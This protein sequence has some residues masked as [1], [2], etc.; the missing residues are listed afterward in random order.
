MAMAWNRQSNSHPDKHFHG[1]TLV[2][3]FGWPLPP[4]LMTT[5]PENGA[6]HNSWSWQQPDTLTGGLTTT[7]PSWDLQPE[8][9]TSPRLTVGS[10]QQLEML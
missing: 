5:W 7:R 2:E 10:G 1:T 3:L 4:G 6:G 9:T 8:V